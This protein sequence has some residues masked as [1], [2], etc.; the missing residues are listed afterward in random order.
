M[1]ID[2]P[3]EIAKPNGLTER[4]VLIEVACRLYTADRISKPEAT[5]MTELSRAEFENELTKRGLPWIR[6]RDEDGIADIEAAKKLTQERRS[7]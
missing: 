7:A 6:I 2:I 3:D 5:R 1:T 4:E